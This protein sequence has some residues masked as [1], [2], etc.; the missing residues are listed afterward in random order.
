VTETEKLS[1]N[2]TSTRSAF[3]Q[4]VQ[5]AFVLDGLSY[6]TPENYSI[7][8]L[9]PL[10]DG[11]YNLTN[12]IALCHNKRPPGFHPQNISYDPTLSA[13]FFG[14][15]SGPVDEGLSPKTK[16][17]NKIVVAVV[18]PVVVCVALA[19]VIA[20]FFLGKTST[21]F[22]NWARPYRNRDK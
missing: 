11:I 5:R 18:V 22:K 9:G 3:H 16:K 1:V 4:E 10:D 2:L 21:S 8:E 12:G 15:L 6:M 17:S 20:L 7:L 14:D 13:A 19:V